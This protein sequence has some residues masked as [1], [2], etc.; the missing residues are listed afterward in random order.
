M[1]SCNRLLVCVL[2]ALACA[3]QVHGQ[4]NVCTPAVVSACAQYPCVQV[5]NTA[6]C[7]C[8]DGNTLGTAA[9]CNA[10]I[11]NPTP[12]PNGIPNQCA[13]AVCPNGATCIP[14][15]QNPSLYICLC[16]N[17]II[18][19]PSCPVNQLPN[20]P[21]VPN[22]PC[23]AGATCVVNTL[24]LQA[25]CLCPPNTYGANCALSCRAVCDPSW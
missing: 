17:N 20:N 2:V 11:V 19:N 1:L 16:P 23:L 6:F 21:C 10:L 3:S 4:N 18:A 14:T 25:V 13:N 5:A 24:T 9:E 8:A 7:V 12:P 15:N 22:N